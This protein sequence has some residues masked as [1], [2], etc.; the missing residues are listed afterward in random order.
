[1]SWRRKL[2]SHHR[3]HHHGTQGLQSHSA[4]HTLAP[5]E[6]YVGISFRLLD[7]DEPFPETSDEYTHR[8]LK[9]D[10]ASEDVDLETDQR[11]LLWGVVISD[12]VGII[13]SGRDY[14]IINTTV[15]KGQKDWIEVKRIVTKVVNTT[16]EA[17]RGQ[18]ESSKRRMG[19]QSSIS[20]FSPVSLPLSPPPPRSRRP[21][22]RRL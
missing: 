14:E 9:E 2:G 22:H 10:T 5:T 16:L 18:S 15:W 4:K 13:D 3:H 20:Q 21:T 7:R 17:S 6:V 11:V 19:R 12:G 8:D 1:M